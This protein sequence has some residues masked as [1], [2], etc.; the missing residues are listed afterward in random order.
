MS[1]R[2]QFDRFLFSISAFNTLADR[3]AQLADKARALY[4]RCLSEGHTCVLEFVAHHLELNE[5]DVVHDLLAFLA[6]QMIEL[7]KQKQAETKRF[8]GWLERRLKIQPKDGLAGIDSLT[9]KTILQGYLGDYQKGEKETSWAD[10]FYRLHQNRGRLGV[11]L[12]QVKGEIE[13][14]YE[15]SLAVLLPIKRQLAATDALIDQVV[16]KLYGLTDEEIAIVERPAYEQALGDAKSEVLKDKALA[17]DPEAAAD[18]IAEKLLPAAQRLQ[19]QV[20]LAAERL[21]L[22]QDLPGWHL[23]PDEVVTF[24]LTAEY[25]IASLPDFLDFSTSVISYAKAVEAMLYHRLFV[26][27]RGEFGSERGRLQEQVPAGVHA[28]GE[29]PDA[30]QHSHHPVEHQ[31]GGAA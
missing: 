21:R 10:F 18:A 6:E 11:S 3:R 1:I 23:F 5:S 29:T 30:G 15:K 2:N 17:K 12:E 31:G 7:N 19:T 4:Q 9:G 25:N 26:R 27:F 14:E 8:L 20:A 13:A 24:L 16:Y 22:D 28:R